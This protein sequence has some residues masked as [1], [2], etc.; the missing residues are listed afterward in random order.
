MKTSIRLTFTKQELLTALQAIAGDVRG[1]KDI[2]PRCTS[3]AIEDP[4][5]DSGEGRRVFYGNIVLTV[6]LDE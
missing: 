6:T 2:D 3:I 5:D 4:S 1:F